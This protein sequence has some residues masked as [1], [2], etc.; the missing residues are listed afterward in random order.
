MAGHGFRSGDSTTC[1]ISV[2]GYTNRP[3]EDRQI[4]T[5]R[6]T[7]GYFRT[8]GMP[9]LLGRDFTQQDVSGRPGESPNIAIINETMAR[10]YFGEANPLGKRFGWGDPPKN[11][12]TEI[13]GVV[14]DVNYGNL[15]EKPPRLIYF[16]NH[17][18]DLLVARAAGP[19]AALSATIRHSIQAVDRSLE[20]S[21]VSDIPQLRNQAL[22][23]ERLL[24]QLSSF[25]GL[26]ALSLAC[27]GL[28]GVMSYDAARRTHEIGIRMALGAQRVHVI[29]LVM[30]ETM[31]LIIFGLIAG[32]G[33]ALASTRLIVSLLYGLMPND[34]LTIGLAGLF[35]LMVA[36]LAGYLP[37]R[38]AAR[39]D[40]MVALRHDQ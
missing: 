10:Y 34:P 11:F 39:V 9:L 26:L 5:N 33:A 21:D 18:G 37:A 14:R 25:F 16:P 1:C 12:D 29:R 23:Q 2:E 13:I 19:R 4:H 32:L 7:P 31:A 22:V 6:V 20:T 40:P 36:A 30:R 15:R 27:V 35:L 24:A 38:R 8:M 17:G 28:Y 3:D